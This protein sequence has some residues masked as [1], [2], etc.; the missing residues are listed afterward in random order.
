MPNVGYQQ[1][2]QVPETALIS[3]VPG[4][5][6]GSEA[7]QSTCSQSVINNVPQEIG[8]GA[9]NFYRDPTC[10]SGDLRPAHTTVLKLTGSNMIASGDF[11]EVCTIPPTQEPVSS[12]TPIFS[13]DSSSEM[14]CACISCLKLGN[15][16]AWRIK[17]CFPGCHESKRMYGSDLLKHEKSHYG[18]PGKYTCLEQDCQIVTKNFGDLKRHYKAKH[19][20]NPNKEQFPCPVPWCKYSGSNGFA[21]KDKLKSHYNNIHEG[22]PAPAKAGR[23][24][25]PAPLI[26][27]V[28]SGFGGN[29]GKQ[30]E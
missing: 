29:A 2:N 27:Q 25:K 9:D 14:G 8:Y 22:K 11:E 12:S 20:T 6:G 18:Q 17:C 26:P 16:F 30:K 3:T 5:S 4:S 1:H 23:A 7:C 10:A 15:G 24:I 13:H 28:S 21:R 19:C